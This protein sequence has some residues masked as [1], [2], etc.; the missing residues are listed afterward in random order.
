MPSAVTLR[1]HLGEPLEAA[2]E[3]LARTRRRGL[4]AALAQ[5]SA[6]VSEA[7]LEARAGGGGAIAGRRRLTGHA[8]E[9]AEEDSARPVGGEVAVECAIGGAEAE[10]RAAEL[11]A[12]AGLGG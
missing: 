1:R 5:A 12:G 3:A 6:Q 11:V 10:A 2:L 8:F 7:S 4:V 9:E